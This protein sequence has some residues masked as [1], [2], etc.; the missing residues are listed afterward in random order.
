[1]VGPPSGLRR[2]RHP[3]ALGALRHQPAGSD[4]CRQ[5]VQPCRCG[6]QG[7]GRRLQ[8]QRQATA[9]ALAGPAGCPATPDDDDADQP[10]ERPVRFSDSALAFMFTDEHGED[11]RYVPEWGTWL[12]FTGRAVARGPDRRR[13]RPA[14][15]LCAREGNIAHRHHAEAAARQSPP[16]STRRPPSPRSSGWPAI[17]PRM[18]SRRT[19][20]TPTPGTVSAVRNS[21][22]LGDS[23]VGRP[24]RQRGK[25]TS[26]ADHRRRRR[27][28]VSGVA[29]V[30]APRAG[31]RSGHDRLPATTVRVLPDRRVTEHA[32]FFLYGSGANGKS[33]FAN[34]LL[35]ILGTGRTGYAA[36]APMT[37]FTAQKF[38]QHPTELAMLQGKRL[39][40]AHETEEGRAWATAR[41]KTLTGG[42]PITARFMR[43]DFFTYEPQFKLL[44]LGNHK[45]AL[46]VTDTAMR[47]RLHLI[48]F[49]VTIPEAERDQALPDKLRAEYPQ[50]LAW[51]IRGA[52]AWRRGG[53]KPPA[54]VV[55]ATDDYFQ[56]E[57]TFAQWL[58][59]C[60]VLDP[61][62]ERDAA[63]AVRVLAVVVRGQRRIRRL[64]APV[65]P[66]AGRRRRIGPR[67]R[68]TPR[69]RR[70]GAAPRLLSWHGIRV[71]TGAGGRP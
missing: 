11:L 66:A 48:P 55:A 34:V 24:D 38:D 2:R 31:R 8:R 62:S 7:A 69:H 46:R 47:R 29:Q 28:G 21:Y 44:I 57:D 26:P 63:R 50:I 68:P 45:P 20:S 30:P 1:M 51:M 54:S 10:P 40:I 67:R 6:D 43:C 41:I 56:D 65:G 17:T 52:V 3:G 5:A 58:A 4:R 60:C 70:Q 71:R 9:A 64:P 53:L 19:S 36:V 59:E 27:M 35:E 14:R 25:T 12:V 32:L 33:T 39:V 13:V 49:T 23:P 42:D 15:A 37:V 61:S 18:C 16:R 22:Y